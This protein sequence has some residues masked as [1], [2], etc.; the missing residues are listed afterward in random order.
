MRKIIVEGFHTR[1][2]VYW[3]F[4]GPSLADGFRVVILPWVARSQILLC[5]DKD[6]VRDRLPR[7][8]DVYPR[9]G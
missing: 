3:L 5:L 9:R 6:L 2:K 4:P 7:A 8:I 1:P